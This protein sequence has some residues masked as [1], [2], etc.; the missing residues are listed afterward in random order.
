[1]ARTILIFLWILLSQQAFA[2]HIRDISISTLSAQSI[3]VSVNTEA[4]ELYYFHS[5][6]YTISE[7]TIT[8]E[9]CYVAGF[10]STIEF[11]NNNFEIPVDPFQTAVYS[12]TVKIY[13]T[14]LHVFYDWQNL[15]DEI[16]GTFSIPL[17]EPQILGNQA[18]EQRSPPILFPNPTRGALTFSNQANTICI[19]DMTGRMV[20]NLL[21]ETRCMNLSDLREGIYIVVFFNDRKQK[22]RKVIV[23][24]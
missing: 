23:R 10:G 24:Q 12:L 5:G 15:Q 22:F 4:A 3:N 13:Y 17:S 1:M 19:F 16:T 14:D 18:L 2:L 9:A 20:R 8:L 11:L 7:N 21:E 6:Q